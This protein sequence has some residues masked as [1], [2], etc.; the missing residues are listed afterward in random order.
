MMC[1][2]GVLCYFFDDVWLFDDIFL[3]IKIYYQYREYNFIIFK[4][5]ILIYQ[6]KR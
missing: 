4:I 5:I 1:S 3:N 6:Y 2:N